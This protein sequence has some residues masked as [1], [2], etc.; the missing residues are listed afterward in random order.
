MGAICSLEPKVIHVTV[1]GVAPPEP[2]DPDDDDTVTMETESEGENVED[3][4]RKVTFSN[5]VD[6][7]E[8]SWQLE[9]SEAP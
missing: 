3:M 6:V 1:D 2:D 5:F 4:I 8:I 9:P 7:H